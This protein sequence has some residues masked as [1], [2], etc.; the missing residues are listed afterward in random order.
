[1]K[2]IIEYAKK[3]ILKAGA[4]KVACT[5]IKS[6]KH[7]LNV[8]SGEISLFRTTFDTNLYLSGILE[9]K[10]GTITINKLAESEIDAAADQVLD[11]AR[12][13]KADKANDIAEMQES[14]EFQSGPIEADLE[15]MYFRLKEF[16]EHAEEA[17]PKAII[18][19]INFDFSKRTSLIMNSNGV[20]FKTKKGVYT[21][22]V[23]FTSKEGTKTSSFNYAAYQTKDMDTPFKDCGSIDRLLE[24]SSEQLETFSIPE[25]FVGN[26]IFTPDCLD[27]VIGN[28]TDYLYQTAVNH[29]NIQLNNVILFSTCLFR[30]KSTNAS[31]SFCS[32]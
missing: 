4:D 31:T 29:I 15:K 30:F 8:V 23:M 1:M 17:Y 24:Q 22:V 11:F 20:D 12:S 3:A 18:E 14:K 25:K 28:I 13:S 9:N 27:T 6:E 32:T 26:V 19:E 5:F 10:K 7:E 21:F 2:K 16:M